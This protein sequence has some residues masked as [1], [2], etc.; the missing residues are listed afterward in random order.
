MS[1]TQGWEQYLTLPARL[2]TSGFR[3][4]WLEYP[5]VLASV[6]GS[7]EP[8]TEI[9]SLPFKKSYKQDPKG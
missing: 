9:A 4:H 5:K 3:E 1:D 6:M 8:Y 7:N 2:E